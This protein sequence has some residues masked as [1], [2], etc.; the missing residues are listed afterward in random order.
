M[1]LLKDYFNG[2]AREEKQSTQR[3]LLKSDLCALSENL[4]DLCG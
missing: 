3:K 4:C 1:G 2:K